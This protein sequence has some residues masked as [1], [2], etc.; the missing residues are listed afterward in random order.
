MGLDTFCQSNHE[1]FGPLSIVDMIHHTDLWNSDAIIDLSE[2]LRFDSTQCPIQA[3]ASPHVLFP[4]F[5]MN[6]IQFQKWT[7]CLSGWHF[8]TGDHTWI[9]LSELG[10]SLEKFRTSKRNLLVFAPFHPNQNP[11]P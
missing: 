8:S 9:A 2:D 10:T 5:D 1:P 7:S 6:R 3:S 11:P 4:W